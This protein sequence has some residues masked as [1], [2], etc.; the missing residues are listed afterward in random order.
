MSGSCCFLI[1]F[2]VALTL[3]L[4]IG[5]ADTHCCLFLV[6]KNLSL[7]C[8]DR[9]QKKFTEI[10]YTNIDKEMIGGYIFSSVNDS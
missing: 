10:L 4:G 2:F 8:I 5:T 1:T 3:F 7:K 9:I 6:L